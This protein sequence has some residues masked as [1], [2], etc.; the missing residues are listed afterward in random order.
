MDPTD[1]ANLA[2]GW[3]AVSKIADLDTDPGRPAELMR[4]AFAG[5]RDAV[6]EDRDWSFAMERYQ[7][8]KDAAAPVFGYS[9]RYLLPSEVLRVSTAEEATDGA[10]FDAFAMSTW[11]EDF[12]ASG[13]DWVKEGRFILAN[14]SAAKLNVRAVK[15]VEDTTIWSPAFCQALAA[16]MAS[17]LCNAITED[18][19]LARDN[20][21]RYLDKLQAASSSDGRQGRAQR[22]KSSWL[23]RRRR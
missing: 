7:I 14:T 15:R 16:R 6:L 13:L 18:K 12:S 4:D 20:E 8:D 22:L 5:L 19:V 23:Q 2:L 1:I 17:D 21:K 9:S 11:P 10:T 3:L